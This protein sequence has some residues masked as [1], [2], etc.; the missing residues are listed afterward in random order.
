[1]F[2]KK[3]LEYIY[4]ILTGRRE[5]TKVKQGWEKSLHKRRHV[6]PLSSES[7]GN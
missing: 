4:M 6:L 2:D 5:S 7:E 3:T 1:M